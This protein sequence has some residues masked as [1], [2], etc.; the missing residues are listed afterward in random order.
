MIKLVLGSRSIFAKNSY[1]KD[2]YRNSR[3]S[4][5]IMENIIRLM[6]DNYSG[7]RGL[8]RW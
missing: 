2:G 6:Y 5:D 3:V 8:H 4:L 1:S 7:I